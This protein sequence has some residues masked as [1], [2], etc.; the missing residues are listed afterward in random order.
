[1]RKINFSKLNG[2]G[3]DFI[4]IDS[5]NELINL[6]KEK[7]IEMC[8]RHFG[9][10]ADG[11]ILVKNS[12]TYNLKMDYYNKDGSVSEMCGNGIRCMAKFAYDR[13]LIESENIEIETLAGVKNIFLDVKNG[14]VGDIMVNMGVPD[15]QAVNIPVKIEGIEEVFNYKIKINSK[16]FHINCVSVG[17]P[18]CVIFLDKNDDLNDFPVQKWGP[19]IE[20]YKIFTNKVN[21]EFVKI[22]NSKSLDMRV[23]ERGVGETLA[24]GT[25]SCAAT[26]AA[27]KLKKITSKNVTVNLKGGN[28]NIIWKPEEL[29]VYLKGKVGYTFDGVY[30]L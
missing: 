28:L 1:M 15:F 8:G 12:D 2:Q 4:L 29:N 5:T 18:H 23:W 30:F 9:I 20:N 26:V 17:N 27:I 11:L 24:C 14:R 16:Y 6:S 3:N 22:K 21:V 10:G 19:I 25:G 7:I 13:K